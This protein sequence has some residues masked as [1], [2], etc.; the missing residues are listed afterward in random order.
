MEVVFVAEILLFRPARRGKVS[1]GLLVDRLDLFSS[2]QWAQL[3]A[4][5]SQIS[6]EV[7][8]I[9]AAKTLGSWLRFGTSGCKG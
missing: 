5:S 2:G 6:Q 1:K 8:F 4:R 9:S 3:I 7:A